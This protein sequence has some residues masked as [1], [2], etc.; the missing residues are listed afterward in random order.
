M[1]S[2]AAASRGASQ[3]AM[4]MGPL[5]LQS[6]A[7]PRGCTT[8][9]IGDELV[10][11][12]CSGKFHSLRACDCQSKGFDCCRDP[13]SSWSDLR[14][15]EGRCGL[16]SIHPSTS[17]K[18]RIHPNKNPQ[19]RT[20][21][22][23]PSKG[24]RAVMV[25]L[26]RQAAFSAMMPWPICTA[27]PEAKHGLALR[28]RTLCRQALRLGSALHLRLCWK[29]LW[30]RDQKVRSHVA[31]LVQ[32]EGQ[33]IWRAAGREASEITDWGDWH[34]ESTGRQRD[35]H[36]WA[37]CKCDPLREIVEGVMLPCLSKV[38]SQEGMRYWL[39]T[40]RQT[41]YICRCGRMYYH[42]WKEALCVAH[43]RRAALRKYLRH[44]YSRLP[45]REARLQGHEASGRVAARRRDLQVL[46]A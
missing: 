7:C 26:A 30:H 4:M 32:Y 17:F 20:T 37:V 25:C 39:L 44:V 9:V 33:S 5:P 24:E 42:L 19:E 34:E 36:N 2:M 28:L 10:C 11:D 18:I 35:G 12:F 38:L 21:L 41:I 16:L 23:F 8:L 13:T 1:S 46:G 22:T 29:L 31:R 40:V 6:C 43:R 14:D 3:L 45:D 27:H 15:A